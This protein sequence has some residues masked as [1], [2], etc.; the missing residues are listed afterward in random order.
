MLDA[1]TLD[2]YLEKYWVIKLSASTGV[3]VLRGHRGQTIS[4]K[5]RQARAPRRWQASPQAAPPGPR[6][7]RRR[8]RPPQVEHL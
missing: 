3:A 7:P 8:R 5:H 6:G 2:A 4:A 1:G